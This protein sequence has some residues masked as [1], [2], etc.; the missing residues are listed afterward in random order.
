MW[1]RHDRYVYRGTIGTQ[2]WV[3]LLALFTS[4]GYL[5]LE[6]LCGDGILESGEACDDGNNVDGEMIKRR[7]RG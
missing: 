4:C 3:M 5:S 1:K 6:P 7:A 2:A